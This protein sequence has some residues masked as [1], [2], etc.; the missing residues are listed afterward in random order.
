[1]RVRASATT[2]PSALFLSLFYRAIV[3]ECNFSAVPLLLLVNRVRSAL[4]S[5]WAVYFAAPDCEPGSFYTPRIGRFYRVRSWKDYR[6]KIVDP[7]QMPELSLNRF[8]IPQD[9]VLE[10]KESSLGNSGC[11]PSDDPRACRRPCSQ[12]SRKAD[13]PGS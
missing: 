4:D 3:Q 1:M 9:D 10:I 6:I 2:S 7:V 5:L 11:G 12:A 13:V 8:M